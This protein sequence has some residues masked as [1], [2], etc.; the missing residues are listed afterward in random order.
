MRKQF[1]E[2]Q[3]FEAF[4]TSAQYLVRLKTQQDPWEHLG[5]LMTAHF[6]ADWAAFARREPGGGITVHHMTPPQAG[7][8]GEILTDE[9]RTVIADVLESGFLASRVIQVQP[10]AMVAFLPIVEEYK[11][12]EVMLIGHQSVEPLSKE[13]LNVYLA[14]AGLAGSAVERLHNEHELNRH[15][16]DLEELV[17]AR[18]TELERSNKELEQFAYISSH[19]LQEPL[20]QVQ[21]FVQL[22]R[23]RYQGKLDDKADQYIQF[24]SD[25]AARMGDLVRGL[26]DYSRVG[27]QD[28]PCPPASCRQALE[29]ALANLQTSIGEAQARVTH[30]E[31]PTVTVEPTQL[32]Q[33]FQNLIGNAVKFRRTGV[34]PEIHVGA[35]QED[36]HWL[37]WVK[38]NGIG[39]KPEYQEKVF[40][41]FQRLHTREKYPGTGIGLAICKKIV[42]HHGG[43]LWI[44]SQIGQ[45]STFY[46]SLPLS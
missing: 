39:I 31:L 46:F 1:S 11:P 45:G 37:L 36:S 4:V 3:L 33:L 24:A 7:N 21:A 22:L 14:V 13:L 25:G 35:R 2:A 28:Q 27:N 40:Q 26:L 10:P 32:T 5:Q 19:D 43:R 34:P 15:R 41:I 20:R 38:D 23:N 8:A 17:K 42:E 29:T 9:V 12:R 30:D 6:P 44:E 18:T 16:A